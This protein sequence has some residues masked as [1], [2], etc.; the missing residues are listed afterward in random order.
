MKRFA[1]ILIIALMT[2]TISNA[3]IILLKDGRVIEAD[4]VWQEGSQ[5]KYRKFGA[6]IGMPSN[7]VKRIKKADDKEK[8]EQNEVKFDMWPLGIHIREAMDIAERN[9]VPLHR[10][11]LVSINKGFNPVMSRKY[12]DT[13]SKFTYKTHLIGYPAEVALLF[14]PISRRLAHI[15]IRLHPKLREEQDAAYR[16]CMEV[17][18]KKYGKPKQLNKNSNVLEK[19]FLQ[20]TG[21]SKTFLWQIENTATIKLENVFS[22]ISISYIHN[23]WNERMKIEQKQLSNQKTARNNMPRETAKF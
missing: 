22:S 10:A 4:A 18:K 19:A 20:A 8:I 3:D 12:M 13:D 14:S 21:F 6:I 16:E 9:N 17:I 7:Q 15:G 2:P 5:I 23:H 1:L 11:E